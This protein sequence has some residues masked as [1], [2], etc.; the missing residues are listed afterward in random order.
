MARTDIA[1]LL[2]GMPSS[3]P[4]PMGMGGNASQQRLAFG[5]QRAEGLQRGVR[6]LMG[7]NTMTPSEQLQMAMAQLDLSNPADLRKLAGI[8]Q[9]TGDLAGAAKTAAGI[10]ELELEGKTRTAVANELI[11]LGMPAEAQQ[12]LDKTLAPAAGQSLVLQVKGEKRRAEST[13]AVKA[14]EKKSQLETKRKATVQ[15]L[16]NKGFSQDSEEVRGVLGGALDSL[17]ES[18]LNSTVNALALYANPKITSDSLTA[19]NTPEGIKMV[20]KWTIETPEGVEQVFGYRNAEGTP[21]SIDPE[22]SK[23]V[24]D[25]AVEGISSSPGRVSKIMIKLST[26]GEEAVD[27]KGQPIAGFITDANDAWSNLSDV[28]KLEVATAV[29]VRA[30]F[31]RKRKGMNQ[32]QAQR[33]AIKE[34]FTDNIYKKGVTFDRTFAD[35]LLNLEAYETEIAQEFIDPS[36][37]DK[38]GTFN[39]IT[40]SG[41]NV[42]FTVT[43]QD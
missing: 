41:I 5:A 29:D 15:L 13:A 26:A 22:T 6:G 18:Q 19:Y 40:N 4:D 32:L 27:D 7:Q 39:G 24:K 1:G 2:T 30:E 31:Y 3:R 43:P 17:S 16:M 10:R 11:K 12:V 21:V 36:K 20:G 34:I 33:T 23:K 14:A 42:L 8:Q 28:K 35:T 37:T 9:A 25:K 38:S